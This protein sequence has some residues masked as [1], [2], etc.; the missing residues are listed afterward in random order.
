ME[1][2]P[3]TGPAILVAR[4]YH[5]LYD[6]AA[7]LTTVPREVHVL[8]AADWLGDGWRLALMRRLA[9]AARW[10]MVWRR[11]VSWR[12]NR[13]G[14]TASLELLEEGRVL[15]VFPEGYP[16]IDPRPS[17]R[18]KIDAILPFDPGFLVLAER[19]RCEVPLVPVGLAYA[20]RDAGTWSIWVRFGAPHRHARAGRVERRAA[21][22]RLE[23]AVRDLSTPPG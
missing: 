18:S 6:A 2:V 11:G 4:H 16:V 22:A 15:L 13:E 20:R 21:M 10:P 14:Y 3:H 5:H 7:I 19:A 8:I 9:A 23:S 1:K 17:R 12:V